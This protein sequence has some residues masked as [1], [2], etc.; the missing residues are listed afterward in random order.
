M[1]AV[2]KVIWKVMKAVGL[3]VGFRC[4]WVLAGLIMNKVRVDD[5][6]TGHDIG[7]E[8]LH[9][10]RDGWSYLIKVFKE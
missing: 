10:S 4:T 1:K 5:N 7:T 8:I 3:Y 6:K 9:E 2:A